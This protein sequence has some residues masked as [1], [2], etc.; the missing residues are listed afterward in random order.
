MKTHRLDADGPSTQLSRACRSVKATAT[1]PDHAN[2]ALVIPFFRHGSWRNGARVICGK[3]CRIMLAKRS[4]I[5][6]GIR[7]RTRGNENVLRAIRSPVAN[8]ARLFG[9]RRRRHC[10]TCRHTTCKR[11]RAGEEIASRKRTHRFVLACHDTLPFTRS[12]QR[13]RRH[14]SESPGRWHPLPPA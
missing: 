6:R 5:P 7:I 1:R 4:I 3:R 11:C 12:S 10:R 8:H 14:Y 2:L 13:K 9:E